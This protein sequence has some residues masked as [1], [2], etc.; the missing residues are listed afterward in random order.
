MSTI[1]KRPY[2]RYRERGG[3]T[4]TQSDY[5]SWNYP[6][7][8]FTGSWSTGRKE[9]ISDTVTP[10]FHKK[11]AEGM[12]IM[13]NYQSSKQEK[14]SSCLSQGAG[15]VSNPAQ[16]WRYERNIPDISW[17][18]GSFGP[19]TTGTLLGA[20]PALHDVYAMADLRVQAS[21]SCLSNIGRASTDNWEN[22]AEMK[23]T[24]GMFWNPLSS[25]FAFERNARARS[26]AQSAA[27]A[28]LMWRYGL[29]PLI[30]SAD[31]IMKAL[32]KNARADRS[33]SHGTAS[34]TLSSTTTGT[35]V[36]ASTFGI[37]KTITETILA[38]ATS[39]DEVAIDLA[40]AAGF[41]A[42]SLLTLPWEL[43]P[44]SFVADWFFNIG[45]YIGALEEAFHQRNLGACITYQVDQYA[46]Q[47]N[48]SHT[49]M[50][51]I[52]VTSPHLGSLAEHQR[53]KVREIGLDTAGLVVK[54]DFRLDQATRIA[55][56]LA[57]VGQ[58]VFSFFARK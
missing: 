54:S 37:R 13:T 27:N 23:K 3:F 45:D 9:T 8:I 31:S 10:G 15:Y 32:K 29:K 17:C 20:L 41:S 6:N 57:L 46:I 7:G 43:I 33:T 47:E 48:T 34:S 42:K 51:I 1:Y 11:S 5:R 25:W 56:A 30:S 16:W 40:Y 18:F 26:A 2:P 19:T 35:Y 49:G 44:Y 50:G 58:Q 38:R 12:I 52:V 4:P 53:S 39:V 36:N 22:I 24:L 21:T 14:Y 28:W 55:D